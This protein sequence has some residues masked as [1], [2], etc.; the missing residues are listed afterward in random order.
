MNDL[1]PLGIVIILV[2]IT[3]YLLFRARARS[4]QRCPAC[5]RFG[6][7]DHYGRYVCSVCGAHFIL[8]S[9][10]KPLRTVWEAVLA[11]LGV[12][13][14]CVACLLVMLFTSGERD[15]IVGSVFVSVLMIIEMR[16]AFREKKFACAE[17]STDISKVGSCSN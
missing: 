10:G 9:T 2:L 15:L 13:L 6:C 1:L 7:A 11:P 8:D 14:L 16:R 3:I 12:N 17:D 5:H 4:N